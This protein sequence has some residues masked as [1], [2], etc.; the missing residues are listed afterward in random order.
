[1]TF[2]ILYFQKS[3]ITQD[4]GGASPEYEPT[5]PKQSIQT[6]VGMLPIA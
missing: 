1:M 4:D 5:S 6:V 2:I 3:D